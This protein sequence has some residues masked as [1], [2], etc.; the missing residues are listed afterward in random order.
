VRRELY[1]LVPLLALTGCVSTAVAVVKAPFQVAG[2]G[3]D[4]MT[5]SQSESDRNRGRAARK[6]EEDEA[7]H[8]R[9]MAKEQRKADE[10]REQD[11]RR[12]RRD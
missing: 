2:K 12:R 8:A 7:K 9:K 1:G 4:W 10:E 6:V 11:E 5:T 3:V